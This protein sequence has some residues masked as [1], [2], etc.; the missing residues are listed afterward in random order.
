MDAVTCMICP[1]TCTDLK[2][3]FSRLRCMQYDFDLST[4]QFTTFFGLTQS[5]GN[6][7]KNKMSFRYPKMVLVN[8]SYFHNTVICIFPKYV[9]IEI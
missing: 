4:T 9:V 3:H 2:K 8:S 6:F 7:I 1:G 5:V